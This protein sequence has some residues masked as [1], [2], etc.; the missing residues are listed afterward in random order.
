MTV[1]IAKPSMAQ[2]I[3]PSDFLPIVQTEE[4]TVRNLSLTSY[5]TFLD[6]LDP[7]EAQAS[8]DFY[9]AVD[10]LTGKTY[11]DKL[12]S[13]RQTAWFVRHEDTGQVRIASEK[14]HL[15]WCYFCSESKQK[16]ITQEVTK[17]LS[18]AA[19][20][21]LLTLTVKHSSIELSKQ[22]SF[23][24]ESF[25]KLRKR[26]LLADRIAGGVWFFQVTYNS[27]TE[28]WHPHIHALIDSAYIP[29][30]QL[31]SLWSKI[32]NGSHVVHIRLVHDPK[33]TVAHNARYAARPASLLALPTEHWLEL[34][35]AFNGRRLCGSWGTA[36]KISLRPQK[37]DDADKWL[38]I[39]SW[40]TIVNLRG[41]DPFADQILNAWS[42]GQPLPAD[43]TLLRVELNLDG[44]GIHDPPEKSPGFKQL[45][46]F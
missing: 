45:M 46:F 25:S 7:G 42:L 32:T 38:N 19:E 40:K 15:R 39:G 4:T 35:T 23:L 14:C 21:K 41:E 22:I 9:R 2:L 27:E 12:E 30:E 36:R 18:Q 10:D 1:A 26:K 28:T 13:C 37:P 44:I 17:W 5:R 34:Y 29:H 33:R 43:V 24:Y 31:K 11:T 16:Y 3:S 20:P 8:S 6:D